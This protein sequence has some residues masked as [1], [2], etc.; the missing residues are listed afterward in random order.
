MSPGT[1]VTCR[2]RGEHRGTLLALDDPRAWHGTLAFGYT[3]P[4]PRLV[5][6]HVA[7]CQEQGLLRTHRPVKWPWGIM[8]DSDLSQADS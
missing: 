2:Y 7:W 8:W 6:R 5:S 1:T 4:S 3:L